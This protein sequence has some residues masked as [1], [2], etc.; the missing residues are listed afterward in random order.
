[1]ED[2]IPLLLLIVLLNIFGFVGLLTLVA[3]LIFFLIVFAIVG[4]T[5]FQIFLAYQV[6]S[7]NKVKIDS[8][9]LEIFQKMMFSRTPLIG[10]WLKQSSVLGLSQSNYPKA[11]QILAETLTRSSDRELCSL[12]FQRLRKLTKQSCVDE[13]CRVWATTRHPELASLLTQQGWIASNPIDV[14]V[15]NALKV[16]QVEAL[17]RE[18][19]EV[20]EPLLQAYE[21]SDSIIAKEAKLAI[22]QL[23]NPEAQE[24]LCNLL[25]M[26]DQSIAREVAIAVNYA[27]R[28]PSQRALFYFLTDQWD[29]YES[30][31]YEY[32]LLQTAYQVGDE[33]LRQRIAQ[34]VRQAGHAEWVQ[35]ISGGH[36]GKRLGEMTREEWETALE[37]LNSGRKWEEMWQLAQTAPPIWSVRLLRQLKDAGWVRKTEFAELVQ[38]GQKFVADLPNHLNSSWRCQATLHGHFLAISPD[39]KLLVSESCDNTVRLWSLP[40]GNP[41]QTLTG[42]SDWVA[43]LAISP[44]SKLLAI[45]SGDRRVRLWNLPDGK[46]FR[47]LTGYRDRVFSL[48]ISSD[49]KLLAS[50]SDDNTVRLSSLPDG[51]PLRTLI[52]H[53]SYVDCL[54]IS[55]DSKL[56]ASGSDDNTV[57]LWSLPD[58]KPFQ[59][60]IGSSSRVRCLAISPDSKLLASGS[61]DNTVRLWSLPDGKPLQTLTGHSSRVCCLAISPDSKL[62]ASGS[63]DNTVRLWSLPDGK[64]LQTLT[65]H[66]DKI[67]SLVISSDGELLVSHSSDKTVR[68]WTSGL[69]GLS[70]LPVEQMS[71]EDM[72]WVQEALQNKNISE[73]E[74]DWL[75]FIQALVNWRRR[76]DVEVEEAPQPINAGEFDIEIED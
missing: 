10:S 5:A 66:N 18:R 69:Y 1:M 54:A 8:E 75:K 67:W 23:Q 2:I 28:E 63:D 30:L 13:I 4:G 31:D 51:K 26:Q 58:G 16:R 70:R 60:S 24:A 32:T 21:D 61:D 11:I 72:Q 33:Q 14:R 43:C 37:V 71:A 48:A 29:K 55:P 12:I 65:G 68:L 27:P 76:F 56:L 6:R 40:D 52:G 41:L 3:G 19:A 62:L 15:L 49:S 38:M 36:K 34:K 35:I 45:G 17:I 20:V 44:D 57:R 73:A 47:T 9:E 46:P 22:Q 59:T 39:S 50:G 53:T 64:P 7:G 74:R 42:Y 25:T